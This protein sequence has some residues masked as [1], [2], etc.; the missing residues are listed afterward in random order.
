M[1]SDKMSSGKSWF[2]KTQQGSAQRPESRP[3]FLSK[4][5]WLLP[6]REVTAFVEL[7]VVN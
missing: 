7:V 1:P 2:P 5:H 3:E 6:R 4:N